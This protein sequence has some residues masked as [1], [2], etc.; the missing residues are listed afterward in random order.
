MTE[1]SQESELEGD[2]ERAAVDYPFKEIRIERK[3]FSLFELHRK[4]SKEQSDIIIDPDFQRKFVWNSKQKSELIES[5][6]MDIPLPNIYLFQ[7]ADGR[8]QVVDGRQR[9]TAIFKFMDNEFKLSDDL[10]ILSE[11]SGPKGKFFKD[12]KP[13]ERAKIEDY[14]IQTYI[15]QPPTPERIKFDIFDRV[16]RGGSQLNNQEMRNAL[17]RGNSTRLIE[18]LAN[19]EEFKKAT[20]ESISDK[21]MKDRYVVIRFLSFYMLKNGFFKKNESGHKIEYKSDIDEFLAKTMDFINKLP[22]KEINFLEKI[23]LQAMKRSYEI[24]GPDCFR[25]AP[26]DK[27]NS[28]PI[29]MALFEALAFLFSDDYIDSVPPEALRNKIENIKKEFDSNGNFSAPID[30]SVKVDY[31]FSEI[32]KLI[33][34]LKNDKRD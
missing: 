12:L 6:L 26:R 29:N 1:E 34:E 28:R 4:S 7:Q 25:F 31:R 11:E 10:R 13:L 15:I 32:N 5:I 33:E 20:G 23:F 21:R 19:S 27:G 16:N 18:K 22:D 30:S 8:Q 14:Q 9:L 3:N 24:S 2:E 17:Y